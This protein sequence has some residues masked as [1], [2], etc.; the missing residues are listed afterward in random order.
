[1]GMIF[2]KIYFDSSHPGSFQGVNK[3]HEANK[4]E[5]KYTIPLSKVKQWLIIILKLSLED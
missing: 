2:G 1:M 3:L 5:G 4:D